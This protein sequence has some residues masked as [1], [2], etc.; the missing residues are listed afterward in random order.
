MESSKEYDRK[1]VIVLNFNQDLAKG[2]G[3]KNKAR[4]SI[5]TIEEVDGAYLDGLLKFGEKLSCVRL[6]WVFRATM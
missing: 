3:Y 4:S 6:N 5:S 1:D 2:T